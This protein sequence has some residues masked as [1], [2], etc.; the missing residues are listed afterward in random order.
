MLSRTLLEEMYT[1]QTMSSAE[2]ALNVGCSASKVNYWLAKYGIS[3]R[4]IGDALYAKH[5]PDGD[6]FREPTIDTSEKAW[7][8][9]VGIGLYWGEG[10]KANK[11]SV[12]LG[13]TDPELLCTFMRFLIELYGVKKSDMRF[14]LQIFT[15]I[16]QNETV[17]YWCQK[18][19]V[20]VAQFYKVHVTQSG[21]IGTYRHKSNYGG[22]DSLLP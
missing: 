13:N 19:H 5:N 20:D 18:L 3:K 21:S 17:E 1:H 10:T 22:R 12:R 4:T 6:P 11:Y 8:H 14:G 15:D 7:L 2:I 9:G 16:D